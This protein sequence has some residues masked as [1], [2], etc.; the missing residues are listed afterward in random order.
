MCLGMGGVCISRVDE[1]DG[2]ARKE[3]FGDGG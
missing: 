3:I 2:V 1:K